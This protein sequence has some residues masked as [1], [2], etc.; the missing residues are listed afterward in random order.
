[1]YGDPALW[2]A[3]ALA[4]RLDNPRRLQIGHRLQIPKIG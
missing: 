2:R 1:M 3:I 4:N